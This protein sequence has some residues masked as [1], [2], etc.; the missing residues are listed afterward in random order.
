MYFLNYKYFIR[1]GAFSLIQRTFYIKKFLI[2]LTFAL[3]YSLGIGQ[4]KKVNYTI[5]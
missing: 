3:V 1:L 2:I 4:A 5:L